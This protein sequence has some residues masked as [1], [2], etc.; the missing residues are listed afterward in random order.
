MYQHTRLAETYRPVRKSLTTFAVLAIILL[1]V[2]ITNAFVCTF[3]FNK[4]LRPYIARRKVESE[5]EKPNLMMEMPSIA[6]GGVA[7]SRMTID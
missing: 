2:T 5:E 4:G 3:N 6:H 1:L 7:P